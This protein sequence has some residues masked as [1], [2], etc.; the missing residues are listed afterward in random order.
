MI[1]DAAFDSY[2]FRR[3]AGGV[4]T[5]SRFEAQETLPTIEGRALSF[6]LELA[7]TSILATAHAHL[8]PVDARPHL[9]GEVD[10]ALGSRLGPGDVIVAEELTGTSGTAHPALAALA[11]AGVTAIIARRIAP[12]VAD[13]ARA[14]SLVIL[15]V[16]TPSF[17]RTDDRVRLDLDAAK[18][19]N[20]S[21][22]DRV[23]IRNL[24]D[25]ERGR[26]RIA[27]ARRPTH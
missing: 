13:V 25:E 3:H 10:I 12:A 19:V 22:G 20:L 24:D 6:G 4:S 7:A 9:F 23:A 14:Q 18:V 26:L 1:P 21:S 15:L 27:L 11:A 16:D 2:V 17:L 5:V 8:D